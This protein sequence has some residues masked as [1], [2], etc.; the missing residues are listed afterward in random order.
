MMINPRQD[1]VGGVLKW[2]SFFLRK[3]A[4]GLTDEVTFV[5]DYEAEQMLLVATGWS[6]QQ[7]LISLQ[8]VLAED[9]ISQIHTWVLRRSKHEPLQYIIGQA[10]FYGH[11]FTVRPGCLI[12]RPETEWLVETS[13]NW[14]KQ[15]RMQANVLELGS[16]SGAVAISLALACPES[17]IE[18]LDISA[19]ASRIA[20]DNKIRLGV[21]NVVFQVA[22]GLERL[23]TESRRTV[24]GFQV[25]VSNPPYICKS[26]IAGLAEEVTQYEPHLALDG[27]I[28]G[29]DFYRQIS[30]VGP[31]WVSRGPGAFFLEVGDGQAA[32]VKELFST[33]SWNAWK[34][35][36][37]CDLRGIQR[38]V[39][40]E[41]L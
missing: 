12:P 1:T 10:D 33:P 32:D 21:A 6:R 19:E 27:G 38:V 23:R 4:P 29:L 40:G 26:D 39:W 28:D 7:L 3:Q 2:A 24:G 18:S 8:D 14:I 15:H 16:G 35:A 17:Q 31:N 37:V 9:I 22:D 30:M 25:F 11:T 36:V 20:E 5:A 34:V 13:A 41:R